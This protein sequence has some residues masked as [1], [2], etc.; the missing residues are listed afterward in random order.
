MYERAHELRRPCWCL[1]G[2]VGIVV[3]LAQSCQLGDFGMG[4]V[5]AGSGFGSGSGW[6][7]RSPLLSDR[8]ELRRHC[9]DDLVVDYP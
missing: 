4:C 3:E 5:V 9:P 2:A 8:R 1:A 7:A 6:R